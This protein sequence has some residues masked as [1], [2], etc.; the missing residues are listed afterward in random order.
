MMLK[1]MGFTEKR[2]REEDAKGV[3]VGEYFRLAGSE[4]HS[5]AGNV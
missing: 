4:P 2:E 3:V 1:L 5:M